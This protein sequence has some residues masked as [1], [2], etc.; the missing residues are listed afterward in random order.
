MIYNLVLITGIPG[1]GKSTIS[2]LLARRLSKSAVIIGD[3]LRRLIKGG[4]KSPAQK[5][6]EET[7]RQYYFSFKNGALLAESFLQ[8]GYKVIVDDALH[9]GNLYTE[10]AKYFEKFY[11]LKVLLKPNKEISLKRNRE[12]K[13]HFVEEKVI[14]EVYD[15]FVKHDY[16]GWYV[17][18]N[19]IISPEETTNLI[20]RELRW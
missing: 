6:D 14:S 10:W 16:S 19:S 15:N 12:R 1:A 18:D 11:P 3:D 20:Q 8:E 13:T 17:I 4:F 5:W 2:D 9:A 7:H